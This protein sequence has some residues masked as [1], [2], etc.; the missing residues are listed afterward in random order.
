MNRNNIWI[1]IGIAVV[2]ITMAAVL[3]Q[4][5][6]WKESLHDRSDAVQKR[7]ETIKADQIGANTAPE[8]LVRFKPGV[9]LSQIRSI[10]TANHD[11][12]TDEIESVSGLAVIDDLDNADAQTVANQ[13]AAMSDTV[14]YAEVNYRIKLDDPIQKDA[15]KDGVY[16][17]TTADMPNDPLFGDQWAL[18]NLGQDGGTKRAD[19]DALEAWSKTKGSDEVVVAVLDS[20]V[21]F[22][23]VD[24]KGN[25]WTRPAN[26][27]AYAD[28]ELGTFN[29][30]NGYNGTD[31]IADPMDDNGHGTH[32]AGI[33]GAEGDNGE[34]ITGINQKVKIMPLKFLGRGGMGTT[35]DAIE[36]INYAID[37]KKNG[38]NIRIISASWGSTSKSKALEDT[39]RAAGDAGILFIA[40]AG[41]DGSN[42]DSR[43]HYPSNYDLPNVISVAA[44]DRNDRLAG[45]SNFGVKTV[46]I[47]APGK[48]ILSTWLGGAYREASGTSMAT[49]YVSGVAAL[50]I[51]AEPKISMEKLRERLL[52]TADKI[53]TL[54]GKVATGGRI[55]AANAIAGKV[56]NHLQH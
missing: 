5:G 38:V 43:P 7:V 51:A 55:C 56:L 32:C 10:A 2:L 54:D 33:I 46:H 19:I 31:K 1:H 29:D 49:P 3:G 47:A 11:A 4:I 15:V 48:D 24:L 8:V 23:H 9:S 25:M 28:D 12:L 39:I 45:F 16:R 52:S 21:D 35:E 14:A 30:M 6:R 41:N 50:I 53:D 13:Y 36:A 37:R 44:L 20:G 26:V 34:G 17:E 40:A 22:T 27:P 42:N 18:N